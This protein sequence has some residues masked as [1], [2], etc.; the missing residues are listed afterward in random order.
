LVTAHKNNAQV[1]RVVHRP[2]LRR[3]QTLT[4]STPA[5]QL[6]FPDASNAFVPTTQTAFQRMPTHNGR[7]KNRT[8]TGSEIK[9]RMTD[10]QAPSRSISMIS[11]S[12]FAAQI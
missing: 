5:C 2:V 3:K 12:T 10:D 4:V 7:M 1:H 11:K 8:L 9:Q 6:L